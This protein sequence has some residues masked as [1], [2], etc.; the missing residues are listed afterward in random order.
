MDQQEIEIGSRAG[1]WLIRIVQTV[2][3]FSAIVILVTLASGPGPDH[4]GTFFLATW[5]IVVL[6][7]VAFGHRNLATAKIKKSGL[8]IRQLFRTKIIP[9]N[10]VVS[11]RYSFWRTGPFVLIVVRRHGNW[12]REKL[13]RVPCQ[14]GPFRRDWLTGLKEGFGVTVPS[15]VVRFMDEVAKHQ[16]SSGNSILSPQ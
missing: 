5:S 11:V 16:T 13:I 7:I 6:L 9:W 8:E 3:I 4:A 12:T 15:R 1:Y 14:S 2:F 10:E